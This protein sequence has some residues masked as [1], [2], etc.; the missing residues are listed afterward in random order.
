MEADYTVE[1]M[2]DWYAGKWRAIVDTKDRR[3][4]EVG[5]TPWQAFWRAVR[6]FVDG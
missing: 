5:D 3:S 6:R 2:T 4:Y 1:P